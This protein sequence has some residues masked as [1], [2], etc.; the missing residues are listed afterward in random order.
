MVLGSLTSTTP[1]HLP[2][3]QKC[4][5]IWGGLGRLWVNVQEVMYLGVVMAFKIVVSQQP[6][7][8]QG[9]KLHTFK[10]QQPDIDQGGKLHTFKA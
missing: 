7:I 9:G 4:L 8:D 6:D 3:Y 2:P 5:I 10:T 1:E